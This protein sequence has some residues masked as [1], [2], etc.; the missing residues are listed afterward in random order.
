MRIR[1]I[2][3]FFMVQIANAE[4]LTKSK[5]QPVETLMVIGKVCLVLQQDCVLIS[6]ETALYTNSKINVGAN[7]E[8]YVRFFNPVSQS[9]ELEGFVSNYNDLILPQRNATRSTIKL[10][11]GIQEGIG[12][13]TRSDIEKCSLQHEYKLPEK[14]K[15]TVKLA[16]FSCLNKDKG[17]T[18]LI[19]LSQDGNKKI[20]TFD[21]WSISTGLISEGS[22]QLEFQRSNEIVHSAKLKLI[23]SQKFR[24]DMLSIVANFP[25]STNTYK[26]N[27]A[28][29]YL[30]GY[31]ALGLHWLSKAENKGLDVS[32]WGEYLRIDVEK[33]YVVVD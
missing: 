3:L 32:P 19:V 12:G 1:F 30:K 10:N 25:A 9:Y 28:A 23:S 24:E 31:W 29:A 7:S 16:P 33:Q 20:A 22:Y 14:R 17:A 15:A 6:N 13:T 8:L 21:E 18:S 4:T 26:E 2:A 27:I 11:S 5:V